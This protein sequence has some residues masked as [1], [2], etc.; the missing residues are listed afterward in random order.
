MLT[1]RS[2]TID[3]VTGLDAGADDYLAKP[4][5]PDELLARIRAVLR[6]PQEVVSEIFTVGDLVIDTKQC[7][8]TRSGQAIALMPKE[9][10]LLE[11][12]ARKQGV[13]VSKQELLRHVWGIY[14]NNSSNRLEVYV[15]YLREKVDEPFDTKLIRTVRGKGYQLADIADI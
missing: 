4:F 6:R 14:S 2:S 10:Q 15:R 1:N 12:L 7:L 13:V 9:F 5:H 3:R 11:Y 8:V